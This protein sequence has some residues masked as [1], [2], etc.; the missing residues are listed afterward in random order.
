MSGIK[1]KFI[2][3]TII[4]IT[5]QAGLNF[6]PSRL[7]YQDLSVDLIQ[8]V[9]QS[10]DIHLGEYPGT[11]I[12]E[13][14][15]NMF[16][17]S[18]QV[19]PTS[20]LTIAKLLREL[21]RHKPLAIVLPPEVLLE[22]NDPLGQEA[23]LKVLAEISNKGPII[24]ISTL[25]DPVTK[26]NYKTD[27]SWPTSSINKLLMEQNRIV[28]VAQVNVGTNKAYRYRIW[29][30]ECTS[31]SK[32]IPSVP[33]FAL[34]L[35][36]SGFS[37]IQELNRGLNALASQLCSSESSCEG[38]VSVGGNSYAICNDI[39][40]KPRL[41]LPVFKLLRET[42]LDRLI[43][44]GVSKGLPA[45]I[46]VQLSALMANNSLNI[47]PLGPDL[48]N[49]IK[50]RLVIIGG[51]GRPIDSN[52]LTP[53][54]RMPGVYITANQVTS[55]LEYGQIKKSYPLLEYI[56]IV[57]LALLFVL[58]TEHFKKLVGAVL[59][60]CGTTIL[61]G[62]LAI[63]SL[64]FGYWINLAAA[65]LITTALYF[66]YDLAELRV[67]RSLGWRGLLKEPAKQKNDGGS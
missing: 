66:F 47:E 49:Q 5:V 17:K 16:Q 41:E 39:N 64:R 56:G 12:V 27:I 24:A 25:I 43:S 33:L 6:L 2:L 54:G 26:P 60:I 44:R 57:I 46:P 42:A 31:E 21:E 10:S 30:P 38:S 8:P 67:V 65:P 20:Y 40:A 28:R 50:G 59:V 9:A 7:W 34:T 13:L 11:L 15:G 55:I 53:I 45:V 29:Q 61:G 3:V 58:S 14:D 63:W 19:F 51:A 4:A 1:T 35:F 36:Q 18:G 48:S 22:R 37:G 23:L 62:L 32:G 52:I